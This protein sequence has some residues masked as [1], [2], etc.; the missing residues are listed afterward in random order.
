MIKMQQ[1]R[2][3]YIAV[4]PMTQNFQFYMAMRSI[5][6][7]DLGYTTAGGHCG[8]PYGANSFGY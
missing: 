5:P 1:S 6:D 8:C 3:N 2:I 4:N 7:K